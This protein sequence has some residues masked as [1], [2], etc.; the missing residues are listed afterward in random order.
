[1][2]TSSKNANTLSWAAN[3]L[4][5][6]MS[7][8]CCPKE[9]NN[10]IMGSP[11]SPPSPCA[12]SCT[13]A[14]SSSQMWCDGLPQNWRAKGNA[15][16]HKLANL[17]HCSARNQIEGTNPVYG[18][19]CGIGVQNTQRLESVRDTLTSGPATVQGALRAWLLQVRPPVPTV[20]PSTRTNGHHARSNKILRCSEVM[21]EGRLCELISNSGGTSSNS[22]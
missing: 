5:T 7:A 2:Y 19:N 4:W 9:N 11:C 13:I 16:G 18:Q 3:C 21:P 10:G 1:M 6:A 8:A 17:Q 12:L 15:E 20:A 14:A 22:N